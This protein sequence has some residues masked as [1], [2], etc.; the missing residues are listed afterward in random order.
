MESARFAYITT[1]SVAEAERIGT[2]LVER[3][4]AACANILPGMRSV[5]RWAGTI[6]TAEEAVLIAK[7]TADRAEPLIAAVTA[8]HPYDEPCIALLPIAAGAR[9]FLDW[10]AAETADGA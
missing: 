1:P 9:G 6:E 2:A 7:T 10:I 3:R 8:L 5:Y 4:L